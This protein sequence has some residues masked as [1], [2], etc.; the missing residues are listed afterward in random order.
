VLLGTDGR[1]DFNGLHSRKHDAEVQL[2]AFDCLVNNGEDVRKLPLWT[3]KAS[4]GPASGTARRRNLPVR[5]RAG[6]RSAPIY[7]G[8]PA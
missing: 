5:L 4:P 8:T 3:R 7:S 2:Y 6:E 1:S